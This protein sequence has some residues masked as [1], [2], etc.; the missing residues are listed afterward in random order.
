MVEFYEPTLLFRNNAIR[1]QGQVFQSPNNSL[2]LLN[3][4]HDDSPVINKACSLDRANIKSNYWK[5]PHSDMNLTALAV[6]GPETPSPVLAISSADLANNLFI[7]ELESN[8]LLT[9][10]TT[11]SLPNIHSLR[12]VP[13]TG[14]QYMVSGNN[15]G[16]AHLISIPSPNSQNDSAEIVKRFNHRKHLR[17]VD[18]EPSIYA[19]S[20]TCISQMAFLDSRL[21]SCYDD[22]VFVWNVNLPEL[23]MRPRPESISVVPGVAS[24]DTC[25]ATNSTIAICGTFGVSLFDTRESKHSIPRL[26]LHRLKP[27][28]VHTNMIRWQPGNEHVLAS[29][30]GDGTVRLWDTRM[31]ET[32]AE[33]SGH[34]DKTITA[35]SW[36]ENDLFTGASDGNIVH[37]D[38]LLDGVD[39][40]SGIGK[41]LLREGFVSVAFDTSSNTMQRV[42][43]RQCGTCLPAL[44][45]Q[46]V[47]MSLVTGG[48][49]CNI[50]LV[51]S[52][53]FL[54]L[55]C[56]IYDVHTPE[57][58]YYL[59]EELTLLSG[60]SQV[61]SDLLLE[62]L[63]KVSSSDGEFAKHETEDVTKLAVLST[64]DLSRAAPCP[65]LTKTVSS[66]ELQSSAGFR[67]SMVSDT[68]S[69]TA[70]S[71]SSFDFTG[72]WKKRAGLDVSTLASLDDGSHSTNVPGSPFFLDALSNE[73]EYTLATVDT[74]VE[75]RMAKDFSFSGLKLELDRL[76]SHTLEA[77]DV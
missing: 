54:G 22:T 29:A 43:E 64:P 12:W 3:M 41:C 24:L 46:I 32:F 61:F 20:S 33:L 5:V 68:S 9:H 16:Y 40:S 62:A 73:S 59:E 44:N 26:S 72:P 51:D 39:W 17:L 18:K 34:R 63:S 27:R 8:N 36:H 11:I 48:G 45:N 57:K 69:Q 71:V 7:Y 30:H 2:W 38:L 49:E 25:S 14:T 6:S 10:H 28:E 37:W 67:N 15:K 42:S 31:N 60:G 74:A 52:A 70:H 35:M 47:G 1:K 55:H 58:A 66:P 77:L 65:K 21:A 56:K 76:C 4:P 75:P 13:G 23:A 50:L 19:H 53:A